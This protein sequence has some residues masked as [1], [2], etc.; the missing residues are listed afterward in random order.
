MNESLTDSL[1][2]K[3]KNYGKNILSIFFPKFYAIYQLLLIA[4]TLWDGS[5]KQL[6]KEKDEH[7]WINQFDRMDKI[8]N[9]QKIENDT[10]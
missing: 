9:K 6:L 7:K 3:K 2:N 5:L 1:N 8:I 10:F 4:M